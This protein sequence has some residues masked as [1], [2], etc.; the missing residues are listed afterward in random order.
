[1]MFF[2]SKS[3]NRIEKG[4]RTLKKYAPKSSFQDAYFSTTQHA[5][6]MKCELFTTK[7][8]QSPSSEI[9]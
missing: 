4:E 1:M 8:I 2:Q 9:V 5:F 7:K 3:Q 6:K